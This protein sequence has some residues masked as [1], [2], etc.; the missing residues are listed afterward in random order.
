MEKI[1]EQ[2][3]RQP[4]ENKLWHGKRDWKFDEWK[5]S[6]KEHNRKCQNLSN[7]N[8][9]RDVWHLANNI[10]NNFTSPSFLPCSE[11]RS[12]LLWG[13]LSYPVCFL[14]LLLPCTTSLHCVL[15]ITTIVDTR[16]HQS[17][18]VT[19]KNSEIASYLWT[20]RHI[21]QCFDSCVSLIYKFPHLQIPALLC[22]FFTELCTQY[23]PWRKLLTHLKAFSN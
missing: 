16:N 2:L 12:G 15:H 21:N 20:R 11:V 4:Q 14:P 10:S 23:T 18:K 5:L 22:F 7:S 1:F 6:F 3:N 17:T 9:S 8:S 19:I 13:S